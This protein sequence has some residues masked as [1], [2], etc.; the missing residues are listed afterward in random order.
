M[1]YARGPDLDFARKSNLVSPDGGWWAFNLYNAGSFYATTPDEM[2]YMAARMI[3]WGAS[4]GLEA[5]TSDLAGN[6]RTS[7][8]LKKMAPW[9]ALNRS[10]L[11]DS[12][13]SMLTQKNVEYEL[14]YGTNDS[15]KDSLWISHGKA[16]SPHIVDPTDNSSMSWKIKRNVTGGTIGIR[17]RALTLAHW[18]AATGPPNKVLLE[19]GSGAYCPCVRSSTCPGPPPPEG[20]SSAGVPQTSP[21]NV[22]IVTAPPCPHAAGDCT[23][24]KQAFRLALIGPGSALDVGCW[25]QRFAVPVNLAQHRLLLA[26]IYGDGSGALLSIQLEDDTVPFFREFYVA[27]NFM[28]WKAI[29]LQLPETRDLFNH[30]GQFPHPPTRTHFLRVNSDISLLVT[31]SGGP[32]PKH[33]DRSLWNWADIRAES[34]R[35]FDWEKTVALGL[36]VTNAP[37]GCAILV[38]SIVAVGEEAVTLGAGEISVKGG[39]GTESVLTL[40]AELLRAAPCSPEGGTFHGCADYVECNDIANAASCRAFDAN[41]FPLED[42]VGRIGSRQVLVP[43]STDVADLT[44]QYVGGGAGRL[45]VTVFEAGGKQVGPLALNA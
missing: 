43:R 41:G 30:S 15:T 10:A 39:E 2:N 37:R 11:P 22:T 17:A 32:F 26:H 23:D 36:F 6:G 16:H 31:S 1:D 19:P 21:L 8:C 24:T 28:G 34:M 45:E 25:R 13:K 4:L 12:V 42:S 44:L 5:A 40:P 20:H 7:E 14:H 27:V 33:F 38:G 35:T 9:F 3:G 18:A 29:R